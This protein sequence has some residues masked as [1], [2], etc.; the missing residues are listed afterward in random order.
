M[1]THPGNG[2]V[3]VSGRNVGSTATYTCDSGFELATNTS[4]GTRT[5]QGDGSWSEPEPQCVGE[6]A[7]QFL[8]CR[9]LTISYSQCL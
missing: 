1:L 4:S 6:E 7:E 3:A 9:M 2:L 8:A 5:C